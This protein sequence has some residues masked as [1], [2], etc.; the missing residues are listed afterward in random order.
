MITLKTSLGS[1]VIELDPEKAPVTVAN[2]LNYCKNGYYNGTVFHRVIK[3]FMIQGGGLTRD[4][5]N[6][7]GQLDPIKNEADNGLSN[8]KYTVAMARTSD[9]H[10]ATSQFFINTKD[11]KF[12]DHTA[13]DL[14]GWGYCVFGKVVSGQDV[15]DKI[16]SVATTR[17]GMYRDVPV[18]P[19][20][21]LQ[22]D[23]E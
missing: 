19:V 2:F 5:E 18:T 1:I 3:G 13:K 11:N 4:M 6:K 20:E 7:K 12:L 8:L 9:P 10:S 21:I 14:R 17:S 16:E 23:V 15:V 22:V